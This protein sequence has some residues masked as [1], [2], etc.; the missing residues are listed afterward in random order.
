VPVS[1]G[2]EQRGV[3]EGRCLRGCL[4]CRFAGNVKRKKKWHTRERRCWVVERI[5]MCGG[6]A[7]VRREDA[8]QRPAFSPFFFSFFFVV[9]V[10]GDLAP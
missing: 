7:K 2:A 1:G 6:L 8:G 9:V 10:V 3:A 4:V 5:C